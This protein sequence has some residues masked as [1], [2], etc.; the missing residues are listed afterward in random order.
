MVASL[1][2]ATTAALPKKKGEARAGIDAAGFPRARLGAI[3]GVPGAAPGPLANPQDLSMFIRNARALTCSAALLLVAML[4]AG[5]ASAQIS[6]T[7]LGA[8]QTQNFDTLA[9][10]GTANP[11][12]DNTVIVGWYAAQTA[13]TLSTYRAGDGSTNTGAIYSFGTGAAAERALGSAASGTPK[14]LIYAARYV[15]NTGTAL[16]ALDVAYTGE[17]WRNGGNATAQK[18]DF[19]YQIANAGVILGANNPATGWIDVNTLDFTGPIATA[20]ASALDGNN[21]ANQAA[22]SASIAM[23]VAPGQEVWIRWFDT[24]DAGNDHGL[25]ID[26]VS[27]TPQ[28]VLPPPNLMIDDVTVTEGNAGTATAIFTVSLSAPAPAGGVTF[29][30]A[31]ADGSATTADND[32]LGQSMAGQSIAAG[33]NSSTFN[34]TVNGDTVLESDETYT[35]D[36]SNV[37]GAT[38][39][40]GQGLG[41]ISND[42]LPP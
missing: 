21:V 40:D 20:T 5:G 4:F 33:N 31:T 17:Q 8:A 26:N 9:T 2:I 30:I 22:L 29:D 7:T 18:L 37:I 39:V 34:V 13:G 15:N 24:N 10:S 3:V 16:A 38:V 6:L 11:W 23:T 41:T 12:T 1:V 14:N 32:Y 42:D 36:V 27:V 35:V 25:G 28:D 19:Q